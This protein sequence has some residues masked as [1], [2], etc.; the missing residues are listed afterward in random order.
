MTLVAGM[1]RWNHVLQFSIRYAAI[2]F[3][4]KT[5]LRDLDRAIRRLMREA[6]TA[7][8]IAVLNEIQSAGKDRG[9]PYTLRDTFPIVTGEA[10]ASLIPL[11]R[12][13][14]YHVHVRPKPGKENRIAEGISQGHYTLPKEIPGVGSVKDN[15]YFNFLIDVKH[16]MIN[17]YKNVTKK[18]DLL[19]QTP[20][21]TFKAGDAAF[22]RVMKHL[23]AKVP[24]VNNYITQRYKPVRGF[25]YSGYDWQTVNN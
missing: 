12:M 21:Q 22:L 11:G 18:K 24:R 13:L 10:K 1:R 17:E 7:W 5:Y 8:L 2:E 6:A 9:D 19:S 20:W 3:D 14:H 16:Y 23:D 25:G 4:G 15:Y